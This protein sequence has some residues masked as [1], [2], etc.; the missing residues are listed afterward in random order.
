M[1]CS[2]GMNSHVRTVLCLLFCWMLLLSCVL[3]APRSRTIRHIN[4]SSQGQQNTA[5]APRRPNDVLVRFRG[6]PT[7]QQ[8]NDSG[9]SHRSVVDAIHVRKQRIDGCHVADS[10]CEHCHS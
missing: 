3:P 6:V 4:R 8:K 5:P 7:A 10:L 9:D 1:R 2:P